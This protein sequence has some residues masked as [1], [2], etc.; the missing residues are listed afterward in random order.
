MNIAVSQIAWTPPEN[1]R[2]V[3][4]LHRCS[5]SGIEVAPTLLFDR[6]H[7]ATE[8]MALQAR[9]Y[10]EGKGLRIVAMQALLFGRPDLQ[11]FGKESKAMFDYL[12]AMIRL[13]GQLGAHALVFGSPKN[14]LR[15]DLPMH[16][17]MQKAVEFFHPLAQYADECGTCLCIEPNAAQYGCDFI[18]T[19]EEGADLVRMVNHPG[20]GL[21]ADSGVM[22]LNNEGADA[23]GAVSPRIRHYHISEPFLEKLTNGRTDHGA[24]RLTLKKI[25]YEGW[26]SIEMRKD[27]E[28]SNAEHVER[29]LLFAKRHYG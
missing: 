29:N 8:A 14:R 11:M 15:F 6:P 24:M 22:T 19:L 3:E 20:F 26:V 17:A 18:I 7:E 10:W 27:S 28:T 16:D 12:K 9:R 2:I 13:G 5:V 21:H 23:I 1:D 4:I 25:G